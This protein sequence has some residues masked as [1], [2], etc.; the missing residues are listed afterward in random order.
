MGVSVLSFANVLNNKAEE[1]PKYPYKYTLT[2]G[3][4]MRFVTVVEMLIL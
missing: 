3:Q 4:C 2:A 1:I